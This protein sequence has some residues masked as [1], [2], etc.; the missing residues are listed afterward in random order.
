MSNL[1]IQQMEQT[2]GIRIEQQGKTF[3]LSDSDSQIQF[4]YTNSLETLLSISTHNA[5]AFMTYSHTAPVDFDDLISSYD[6]ALD[7][8]CDQLSDRMKALDYEVDT[9]FENDLILDDEAIS[10]LFMHYTGITD[11]SPNRA[12]MIFHMSDEK[13]PA[14]HR[15]NESIKALEQFKDRHPDS[16]LTSEY[17]EYPEYWSEKLATEFDNAIIT[18]RE[19]LHE[20]EDKTHIDWSAFSQ[21]FLSNYGHLELSIEQLDT[22]FNQGEMIKLK[23]WQMD[24]L[25]AIQ[26]EEG[27]AYPIEK[28]MKAIETEFM[29]KP[30]SKHKKDS[31]ILSL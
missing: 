12:Y 21:T 24:E 22:L 10:K 7:T 27:F 1:K 11:L 16:E 8:A 17:E 31:N 14:F 5:L 25:K 2:F 15:V 29:S 18:I 13:V 6:G 23:P 9:D 20:D 26:E 3:L 30:R 28:R 4:G 19:V